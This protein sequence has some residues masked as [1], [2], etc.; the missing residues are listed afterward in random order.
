ML[1]HYT[2]RLN[3]TTVIPDQQQ[4]WLHCC[5]CEA[6]C[7]RHDSALTVH[8]NVYTVCIQADQKIPVLYSKLRWLQLADMR[9]EGKQIIAKPHCFKHATVMHLTG[10]VPYSVRT[11][12]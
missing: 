3:M 12:R 7:K 11:G 5:H 6:L 9:I 10:F 2:F 8:I 4:Q 1:A